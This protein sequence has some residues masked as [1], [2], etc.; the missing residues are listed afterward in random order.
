MAE[1]NKTDI[2][3][4]K[5]SLADIFTSVKNFFIASQGIIGLD[6]GTSYIK[7]VQ[8]QKKGSNYLITDYRVRALPLRT[9]ANSQEK[10]KM[11]TAFLKEF[12]GQ[13]RIKTKLG[14]LSLWG[15]GCYVFSFTIP[16]VAE[17]ELKGIVGVELKKKLPFQVDLSNILYNFFITDKFQE[18]KGT[19]FQ[20]T[21]IAVDK[22]VLDESVKILKDVDIRPLG[23]NLVPDALGN[24]INTLAGKRPYSAILDMGVKESVLS[25]YKKGLL[26]FS[27][28]IPVGGDQFTQAIMKA[29]LALGMKNV[30]A[31]D[32]EKVK[33][34][35]GVPLEEEV[36]LEYFTDYGVIKG[37][38]IAVALRPT[39]ERFNTEITR[40]I[41]YY[42]R[43]FRA[44]GIDCLYLTGGSSR[45][46]NIDK[47]L[48]SNLKNVN[49]AGIEKINPLNAAKGWVDSGILRHELVME[50][51]AP[52][53]STVF[54]L[55]IK[56]GGKVN[57][58]PP[59][60]KLEQN[61]SSLAAITRIAFVFL[62]AII[63]GI[64]AFSYGNI[65]RYKE[66]INKVQ[67]DIGRLSPMVKQI[68]DYLAMKGILTERKSL[69]KNA[70]GQQPLW[71][72]IL[73]ELSNI[74]PSGAAL[75]HLDIS[76]KGG[77]RELRLTGE[78]FA[79]YTTI[80]VATSQYLIAL[81][82]S[83]FFTN[84]RLISTERDVYSPVPKANFEIVC[85]LVY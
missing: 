66:Q 82:K 55:C 31:E 38:Q 63:L 29:M 15:G 3:K 73:K 84:V 48:A 40:T 32:A 49:I 71:W 24:L 76:K 81:G 74:T 50:E 37:N 68:N 12:T 5:F 44:K 4:D 19:T 61:I 75:R 28:Q 43:T 58:L 83:P 9:K 47:L 21:C 80:D 27:R 77:R 72:G 26:Q 41:N 16:S 53:L 23:I 11:V 1:E 79:Q 30:V 51:A 70:I 64:Y 13:A 57:L 10:N 2:K 39:L 65:L 52:H 36:F 17:K 60:E 62:L 67:T 78:V 45:L 69:L 25:F 34:Q 14:R 59:K 22:Y 85:D 42:Y 54:G 56:K 46:K 20:V 6:V 18:E 8:L 33:R 7:I 35:C